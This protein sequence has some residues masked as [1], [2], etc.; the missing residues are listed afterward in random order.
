MSETKYPNVTLWISKHEP[1]QLRLYSDADNHKLLA[2]ADNSLEQIVAKWAGII[3]LDPK[4][5]WEMVSTAEAT[6]LD[7]PEPDWHA[8]KLGYDHITQVIRAN[9]PARDET[10]LSGVT[11][12]DDELEKFAQADLLQAGVSS[13]FD[14]LIGK[15]IIFADNMA[16]RSLCLADSTCNARLAERLALVAEDLEMEFYI[17]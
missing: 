16:L 6:E 11:L 12:V 13:L 17:N 8:D 3:G 4:N 2:Q 14:M 15:T 1:I 5:A 9:L 10:S 7:F